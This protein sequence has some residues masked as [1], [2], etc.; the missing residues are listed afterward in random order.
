MPSSRSCRNVGRCFSTASRGTPATD[1]R[2]ASES[3]SPD[4]DGPADLPF[5]HDD[6]RV[7]IDNLFVEGMLSPVSHEAGDAL[8]GE[9]ASVGIHFDSEADKS[10]RL[11]GLMKAVGASIPGPAARHRDWTAFAY[12]WAELDVLRLETSRTDAVRDGRADR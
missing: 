9:W 3:F 11:K 2:D 10:R 7:Y 12:R 8:H 6:V 5:D 4:L 1:R